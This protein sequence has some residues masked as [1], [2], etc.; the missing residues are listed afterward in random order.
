MNFKKSNKLFDSRLPCSVEL[1][2]QLQLLKLRM[3]YWRRGRHGETGDTWDTW[4]TG[5]TG[6]TGD[7][8]ETEETGDTTQG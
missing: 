5:D 6:D 8:W 3:R 1:G 2:N 7:S 4:D